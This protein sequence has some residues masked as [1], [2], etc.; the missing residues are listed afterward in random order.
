[1]IELQ[2]DDVGLTA[3]DAGMDAKVVDHPT[4]VVST[5]RRGIAQ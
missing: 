2:H 3:V 4:L 1:M 5:P